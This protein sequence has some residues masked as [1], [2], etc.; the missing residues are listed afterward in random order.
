MIESDY[1]LEEVRDLIR[2][3]K[4]QNYEAGN[5]LEESITITND[6]VDIVGNEEKIKEIRSIFFPHHCG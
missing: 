2:K 5:L 3:I 4:E 6:G 1:P